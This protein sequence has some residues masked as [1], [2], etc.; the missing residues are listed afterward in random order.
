MECVVDFLNELSNNT[1]TW[2]NLYTTYI[3]ILKLYVLSIKMVK[4]VNIYI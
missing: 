3:I 4:Y 2:L 1:E